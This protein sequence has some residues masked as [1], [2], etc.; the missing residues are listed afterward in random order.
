MKNRSLFRREAVE[1]HEQRIAHGEVFRS[2]AR[3][4]TPLATLLALA[5]VA[6]IVFVV[7]GR[8]HGH[9]PAMAIVRIEGAGQVLAPTGGLIATV[10]VR[11]GAAVDVGAPLVSFRSAEESADLARFDAERAALVSRALREPGDLEAKRAAA[12]VSAERERAVLRAKD[13]TVRA[14]RAGVVR[15][16][17]VSSGDHVVEGQHLVTLAG[18][19][20]AARLTL[21][22]PGEYRPRLALGRVARLELAG[23]PY[24]YLSAKIERIGEHLIGPREARRALGPDMQDGVRIDGPTV[25]VEARLSRRTFDADGRALP[26]FDGM[27]ARAELPIGDDPVLYAIM[28][29]LRRGPEAR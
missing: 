5:L 21:L 6:T 14:E 17:L 22:V 15:D 25:L 7:F 3:W 20:G 13:R 28:P 12:L 8:V 27:T 11:P 19:D 18:A 9:V 16:V 26:L 10:H 1:Y 23:Y 24:T 29:S 4:W 2:R